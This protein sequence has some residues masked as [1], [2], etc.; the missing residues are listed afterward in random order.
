MEQNIFES[1]HYFVGQSVLIDQL[2]VFFAKD[3]PYFILL[4]AIFFI[5]RVK[6]WRTKTI[7]FFV[8]A[9]N[10][11]IS[12]GV[13]T[14]V[15]RFFYDRPRPFEVLNF[16]PLV[17]ASSGSF[18]SGHAALF[19][20]LGSAVFNFNHRWGYWFLG[21]SLLNGLARVFVGVHW[22]TD[23]LG[24]MVLGFVSGWLVWHYLKNFYGDNSEISTH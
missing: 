3:L 19:F 11:I 6:M 5:S 23:I 9:L 20:A 13:L 22:P 18:P 15:I 1:I 8:I 17:N 21:F 14:E 10:L 12:R 7:V 2:A 24:G 4:G 16:A